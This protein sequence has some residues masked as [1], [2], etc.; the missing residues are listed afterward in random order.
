[1]CEAVLC[2]CLK[3]QKV[4]LQCRYFNTLN[5]HTVSDEEAKK[6][7]STYKLSENYHF[8][9]DFDS[10]VNICK[11]VFVY[12]MQSASTLFEFG[13]GYEIL[14][15]YY[16]EQQ[17]GVN[18]TFMDLIERRQLVV[19]PFTTKLDNKAVANMTAELIRARVQSGKATWV[20]TE[21]AINLTK[22]YT[23]DLNLMMAKFKCITVDKTSAA[24]SAPR[25]APSVVKPDDV[26]RGF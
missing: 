6:T 8:T 22:E 3:N 20:F 19:I 1:M 15:N 18:R 24:V 5:T 9:G 16:V 25:L 4:E 26:T 2:T 10:F 17:D 23:E 12:Y 14:Q 13:N 11:A 7:A 21:G